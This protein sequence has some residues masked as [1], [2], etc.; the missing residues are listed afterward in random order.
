MI[1]ECKLVPINGQWVWH[2]L[3][4][5]VWFNTGKVETFENEPDSEIRSRKEIPQNN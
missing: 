5:N 4:G 3:I 1:T 2:K